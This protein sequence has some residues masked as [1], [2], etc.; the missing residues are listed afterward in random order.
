MVFLQTIRSMVFKRANAL[1][2]ALGFA[3]CI[4]TLLAASCSQ[5]EVSPIARAY[6]AYLYPDDL[7]DLLNTEVT[8]IDSLNMVNSYIENWQRQQ[9]LLHMAQKQIQKNPERFNAQIEDYKNSLIIHEFEEA[10][11]KEKLDTLVSE[12][13]IAS[14]YE[15]H[16]DIFVLKRPIFKVSYLQL[17]TDA[18]ELDRVKRWFLSNDFADQNL[19]QQY[20]QTYSPHYSLS[21]TSWYYL[22]ELSKKMPIEQIDENNY[23]N[24]GR[25]FEINEKNQLYLIILRDSKLRNNTSPLDM[26]R[27][28]IRNL[29]INQR[30]I[31]LIRKEE[32]QIIDQAR[33]N[34]NIETYNK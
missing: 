7:K 24:Y 17:P 15:N 28:N 14:Y 31:E 32:N 6:N 3:I 22:E 19:L 29:L 5:K 9:V 20:C 4:L 33:Q 25:I 27:I 11:L 12:N 26:E 34:N 18:P 21:D 30:K 16:Q 13:E 10:L 2:G 23:K 8:G 1:R